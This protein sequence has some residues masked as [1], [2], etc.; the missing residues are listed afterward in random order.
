MVQC[1]KADPGELQDHKYLESTSAESKERAQQQQQQAV[2]NRSVKDI[3]KD[4][5]KEK[6]AVRRFLSI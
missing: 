6:A 2:T 4:I 5:A 3:A 1:T